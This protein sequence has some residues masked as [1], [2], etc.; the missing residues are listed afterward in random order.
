MVPSAHVVWYL[1][2][3][4]GVAASAGFFLLL[5]VGFIYYRHK[6]KQ[7]NSPSSKSLMQNLSS[8]SSS[9]DPEK[10][11]SAH[12]Q[13][14]L[15]SYEELEEATNHFDESE[16][17]GDGG[18]GTVYKGTDRIICFN[19]YYNHLLR[20]SPQLITRS[21]GFS[22]FRKASRW[23]YCCSQAAIREQLQ[24]SRA[25]QEWDRYPI[26]PTSSEPCQPLWLHLSQWTWAPPRVRVRAKWH[27]GGSP[28]WIPGY[29][30][31]PYMA[32]A[33]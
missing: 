28:P 6:K 4:T 16:E 33:S 11:S 26:P 18:F 14:H 22:L 10:G 31:D 7:G 12:F 2:W 32:C 3:T 21:N 19:L 9:K 24:T 15:F 29:R 13:T 17:L 25:V 27:S 1:S 5:C 23:A 20:S 8:M 30:G